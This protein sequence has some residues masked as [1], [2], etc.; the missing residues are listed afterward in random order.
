MT[1]QHRF[2]SVAGQNWLGTCV[3][4]R[5]RRSIRL[6]LIVCEVYRSDPAGPLSEG[7]QVCILKRFCAKDILSA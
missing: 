4:A 3:P 6:S 7:A 5:D 1:G 2:S